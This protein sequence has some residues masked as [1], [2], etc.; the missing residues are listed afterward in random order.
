MRD[1]HGLRTYILRR[2]IQMIITLW[3]LT[4]ALF[5]MFRLLPGDPTLMY[6]DAAISPE[7]QAAVREQFG[8]DKPLHE[9]YFL[10][11][12]NVLHGEFGRS[13]YYKVPVGDIVGEKLTA[14]VM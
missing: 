3:V 4:T 5:F 13:F 11:M 8:L 10:Y 12:N 6:I 2:I 1:S 7:A 14:T 9:Q